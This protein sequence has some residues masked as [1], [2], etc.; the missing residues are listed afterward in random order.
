M[1]VPKLR[2]PE[3][4]GVWEE[5]KLGET[6]DLFG[7]IGFRGYRTSDLVDKGEGA[8]TLGGK[9]IS[10]NNKLDLTDPDYISWEKYY[11][12]P[13]IMIDV[14]D[15]ITAQRGTLG[16]S[17]IIYD[18]IGPATINPSMILIKNTKILNFFLYYYMSNNKFIK[19][20]IVNSSST[21]VP[22]I[23]QSEM[24]KIK[25]THP[26]LKEQQKIAAFLSKVDEKIEKI[27]KKLQLWETY[28]KGMMQQIFS[29][30]LRFKD[31][32]G[33]DY[34]D[35]EEKRF[36]QIF[37]FIS[38]NSFSRADLNDESGE[39]YNIHYGDIHTRFPSI[40]DFEK[41]KAP[42]INQDVDLGKIK[43]MSYCQDGD[44]LI[45]DASE[46]YE[47][48]GKTI[49]LKNLKNKKVLGGLHT[50][51][52]RDKGKNTKAGYRSYIMLDNRVKLQIKKYATGVSVLGISKSNLGKIDLN[53]P[54][55]PEQTKIS[56]FL[57][58]I[59]AKIEQI[60]EE[61]KINKEFKKGLLQQ[62]FC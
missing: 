34:P 27:K 43:S 10:K 35:W 25:I 19:N 39:V 59:N 54:S 51:L 17:A 36:N 21:A 18:D 38:T 29:Q 6:V 28:K 2:F 61:S 26:N 40:L 20:V 23:S 42:F 32:N 31:E 41:I 24:K 22:M 55:L 30:K 12:S 4:N 49:E 8:I 60:H 53:I 3:F 47:D 62:M 33:E 16:R 9:H 15:I 5:K 57:S 56:G 14:G 7:R 13:E 11:E 44:L 37:N 52:A 50:L 48:I 45:A 58:S 1:N 46:D